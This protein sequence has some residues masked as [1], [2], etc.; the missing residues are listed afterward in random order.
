MKTDDVLRIISELTIRLSKDDP[1]KNCEVH[2]EE[3]CTHVDGYLCEMETCD[4]LE[5]FRKK[6]SDPRK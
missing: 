6:R 2:K 3:G 1:V 4:I 5:N